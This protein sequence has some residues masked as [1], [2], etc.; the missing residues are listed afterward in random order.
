VNLHPNGFWVVLL[1]LFA[2]GSR[3]RLHYWPPSTRKLES[4]HNHRATFISIPL[5]GVFEEK[6]YVEAEGEDYEVLR[7]HVTSSGGN[8]NPITSPAGRGNVR[9]VWRG[10]RFPL[11]PYRCESDVIHSL[12][13]RTP[14]ALSIIYFRRP[15]RTPR[16]WIPRST[17]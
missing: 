10:L 6:R 7:C 15:E 4:P 17:T 5:L 16:A 3:L 8:G 11:V 9:E 13:P 14:L 12:V 1:K 2:S